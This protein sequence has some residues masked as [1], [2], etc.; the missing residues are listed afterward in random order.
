[1]LRRG[2]PWSMVYPVRQFA[3][4]DFGGGQVAGSLW[5]LAIPSEPV[6]PCPLSRPHMSARDPVRPS[7]YPARAGWTH[8]ASYRPPRST[9][10]LS[11]DTGSQHAQTGVYRRLSLLV[12]WMSCTL[13]ADPQT[14]QTARSVLGVTASSAQW[15]SADNIK[16]SPQSVRNAPTPYPEMASSAPDYKCF[17]H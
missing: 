4:A 14:A 17:G 10:A 8:V 13:H 9:G 15:G 1:M 12:S 11:W 16:T 2:P 5:R 6:D 7:C 3:L